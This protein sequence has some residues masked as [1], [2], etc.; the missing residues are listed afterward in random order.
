M[1]GEG[2]GDCEGDTGG[3]RK[4]KVLRRQKK[5]YWNF[6]VARSPVHDIQTGK[7]KLATILFS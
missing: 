6:W 2:I 3:V 1:C 7:T 4:G 5:V